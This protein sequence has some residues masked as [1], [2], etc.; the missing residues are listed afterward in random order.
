MIIFIK[1]RAFKPLCLLLFSIT[2]A[3]I[4]IRYIPLFSI[5]ATS[6]FRHIPIGIKLN[7]TSKVRFGIN[8]L[9]IIFFLL[10]LFRSN[11]FRDEHI[12]KFNDSAYYPVTATD[13]L[14]KDKISGNIF[15]S[16]NKSAFLIFSLSPESKV[17][18][19]SRFI[20]EERIKT[21]SKIEGEYD[22]I[23]EQLENI[24]KLIPK[25]IG[26]INISVNRK[27]K[28]NRNDNILKMQ[29][30]IANGKRWKEILED[31]NAEIIIHEA[32]NLYSGNIYPFIFK[33]IQ[34]DTWKLIYSDGNVLIFVKNVQKFKDIIM[35]YNKPKSSI[36]DQ[37]IIEGLRGIGQKISGYYSSVALALLL[38][39]IANNETNYFIETALSVDPNNIIAHYCKSLYILMTQ[40]KPP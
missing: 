25:N 11:P 6:V 38:K 4:S 13:F 30:D 1:Q 27:E 3:L 22:S 39:G 12:Y 9:I 21:S 20:S 16:Y 18:S 15:C 35:K 19:D 2:P 10:L 34:E 5:V 17:Y 14:I 26:T 33:L 40:K 8:I 24:N 31:I 37:I 29:D 32:V 36:Y 23:K 7:M 28:L